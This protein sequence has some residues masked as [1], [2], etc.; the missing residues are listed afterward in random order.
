[1]RGREIEESNEVSG[2]ES[3]EGLSREGDRGGRDTVSRNPLYIGFLPSWS[4]RGISAP[5]VG[6][7]PVPGPSEYCPP[8]PSNRLYAYS[9]ST[10]SWNKGP[11][12]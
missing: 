7:R 1:M 9:N 12:F 5:F 2:Q 8:V 10:F 6:V 4:R 11:Y 3:E